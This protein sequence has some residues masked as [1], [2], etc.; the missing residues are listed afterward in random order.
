MTFWMF[1]LLLAQSRT[2]NP[3]T[4]GIGV[5]HRCDGRN[6]LASNGLLH[7]RTRRRTFEKV[8]VL[9]RRQILPLAICAFALLELARP[10][11]S[12]VVGVR[13][14]HFEQNGGNRKLMTSPNLITLAGFG[15]IIFDCLLLAIL[16]TNLGPPGAPN[17]VYTF[18]GISMF[19]YQSFDAI[20]GK[21][22]RRTGTSS[23]LGELFDHGCDALNTTLGSICAAS[24]LGLGTTWWGLAILYISTSSCPRD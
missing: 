18:C 6:N 14:P 20:D 16:N 13:I 15:F 5:S 22:A 24:A 7:Q 19:I 10:M 2:N 9:G 12:P 8:Q 1:P 3:G 23:P 17:W 11:V 21:Q 4:A